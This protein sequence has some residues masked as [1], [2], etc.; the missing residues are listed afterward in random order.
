MIYIVES[1]ADIGAHLSVKLTNKPPS[2]YHDCFER[3]TQLEILPYEFT[4]QIAKS[5]G[6]R[7]ISVHEYIDNE[8]V[9]TVVN[10]TLEYFTQF[11]RFIKQFIDKRGK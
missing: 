7:N 11:I 3:L 1:A 5:A 6:L 4:Q 8:I 10:E 2:D 9:Y